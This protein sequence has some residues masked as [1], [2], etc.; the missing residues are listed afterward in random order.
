MIG[1]VN[2]DGVYLSSALVSA[3][4][5]GLSLLVLRRIFRWSGFYQI[6]WHHRLVNLAIFIIAWAAAVRI[7]PVLGAIIGRFL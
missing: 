7:L 5:A 3:C 2:L 4:L 6:V 1:E